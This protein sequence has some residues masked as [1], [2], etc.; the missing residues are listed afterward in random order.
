MDSREVSLIAMFSALWTVLDYVFAPI[1]WSL[2]HLPF[3]CDAITLTMIVLTIWAVRR[4]GSATLV[5]I[6]TFI[7]HMML[8]PGYWFASWIATAFIMDALAA[9]YGYKRTFNMSL[10]STVFIVVS[11]MVST[12]VGGFL[13]GMT[14][15]TTIE[16]YSTWGI[17]HSF[18][19]F[20]ASLVSTS[21]IKGLEMRGIRPAIE[22]GGSA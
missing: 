22:E 5:A 4:F 14:M 20:L 7:L 21:I 2:T 10:G 16:G 19:G 11:F 17:Y 18:G 3:L 8:R 6:I 13:I 15:F 9:A 12:F 1:F